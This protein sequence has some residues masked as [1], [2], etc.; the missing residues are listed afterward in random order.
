V[1]AKQGTVS[2]NE[3]GFVWHSREAAEALASLGNCIRCHGQLSFHAEALAGQAPPEPL[4]DV[5]P[6]KALGTPRLQF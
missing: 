3:C 2:C 4:T 5:P 6:F 1:S